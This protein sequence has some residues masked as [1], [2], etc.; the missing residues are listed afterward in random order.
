MKLKHIGRWNVTGRGGR[1]N[2]P[3]FV[4]PRGVRVVRM[5]DVYCPLT[6]M[7][8]VRSDR[9]FT[10]VEDGYEIWTSRHGTQTRIAI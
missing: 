3:V 6:R 1:R 8:R 10:G 2:R 9:V 7:D 4:T 5:G